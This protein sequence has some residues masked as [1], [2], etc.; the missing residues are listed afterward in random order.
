MHLIFATLFGVIFLHLS[1]ISSVSLL[2]IFILWSIIIDID[3][4]IFLFIKNK[5]VHIWKDMIKHRKEMKPELYLFHTLEF[6]IILFVFAFF[7]QIALTI[8]LASLVHIALD[9]FEHTQYHKNI[10]W[11]KEWSFAYKECKL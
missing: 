3:H 4:I 10:V 8:F 9:I 7:S 2:I 6:N 11:I 1:I 5:S